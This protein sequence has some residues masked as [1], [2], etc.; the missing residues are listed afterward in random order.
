[1][2]ATI[3]ARFLSPASTVECLN[4]GVPVKVIIVVIVIIIV[5][6][7]AAVVVCGY[8]FTAEPSCY[9]NSA[10]VCFVL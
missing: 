5:V 7:A 8:A 3:R 6:A 1:M 10:F 2:L 4:P 9:P